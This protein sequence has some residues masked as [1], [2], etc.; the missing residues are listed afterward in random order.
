LIKIKIQE[1]IKKVRETHTKLVMSKRVKIYGE[2]AYEGV[3]IEVED[4]KVQNFGFANG[5][6]GSKP[7]SGREISDER[8][9][10]E[11]DR[12]RERL[13][14]IEMKMD[15]TNNESELKIL[16]DELASPV[17]VHS[18]GQP[19]D[20]DL[21]PKLLKSESFDSN[22]L[23][24]DGAEAEGS[25]NKKF[26]GRLKTDPCYDSPMLENSPDNYETASE[27]EFQQIEQAIISQ[28]ITAP[29]QQLSPLKMFH[30]ESIDRKLKNF[31]ENAS[32]S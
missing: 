6:N 30:N 19:A 22:F 23:T 21:L 14:T 4:D 16:Q 15:E 27:R 31:Q 5:S 20:R 1:K 7:N 32:D 8:D 3:E 18:K 17:T 10:L 28:S 12:Q 24:Q 9:S 2:S 11:A 26:Y 29:L 25:K 13:P